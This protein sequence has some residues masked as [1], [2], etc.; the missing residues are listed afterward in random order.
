MQDIRNMFSFGTQVPSPAPGE[1]TVIVEPEPDFSGP[2]LECRIA[3]GT[4]HIDRDWYNYMPSQ[5]ALYKNQTDNITLKRKWGEGQI[6][7]QMRHD[8]DGQRLVLCPMHLLMTQD[9][10]LCTSIYALE[11]DFNTGIKRTLDITD[12]L[13]GGTIECKTMAPQAALQSSVN[14]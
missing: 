3:E 9:Q 14:Y 13:R 11:N 4:I 5:I 7:I 12:A 8:Q 6:E 10:V 1:K 2:A